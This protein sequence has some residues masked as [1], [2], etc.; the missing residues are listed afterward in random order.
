MK[1]FFN[2]LFSMQLTV[3]LLLMFALSIAIATFIEN[4]YGPSAAKVAVYNATWFEILLAVL[5]VNLTGSMFIHKLWQRKRYV[6]FFMHFSFVIIILG[7]AIT[8][9]FGYEGIMHIREGEV[10]NRMLSDNTYISASWE[11]EGEQKFFR[12]KVLFSGFGWQSR[13]FTLKD[14]DI[15]V[16]F[17]TV[18][19]I[20]DA[21]ATIRPVEDGEPI[22]SLFVLTNTDR[23]NLL[24]QSGEIQNVEGISVSFGNTSV[25]SD[26]LL[27]I[28]NDSLFLSARD[29]INRNVMGAGES[30]IIPPGR[31]TPFMPMNFYTTGNIKLVLR[32]F[33]TRGMVFPSRSDI[34]EHA[35]GQDA[36]I[37]RASNGIQ[38]KDVVLWGRRGISGK[39]VKVSGLGLENLRLS[40]GSVYIELPFS[41][42]LRDFILERYPA[43]NSPSSY[44]S[45]IT[46]IDKEKG[47]QFDYRIFMNNILSHRGYRFYQSSYDSDELGTILSVNHDAPGTIVTYAGYA[48]MIL[49]MI[50][51]FIYPRTRFR[52]LL[53][54][55]SEV[56]KQ[57]LT[58]SALVFFFLLNGIHSTHGQNFVHGHSDQISIVDKQHAAR[59]GELIVLGPD[60][61]IKPLNTLNSELIRKITG[62]SSFK[63][64][65]PDQIIL[66]MLIEP[67]EWQHVP[68]FRVKNKNIRQILGITES[69]AR[70]VDFFETN[71]N[72]KL[73][74]YVEEAYRKNPAQQNQFDKDIIAIDE[75]VNIFYNILM[76]NYLHI[77]PDVN[78][79]AERWYHP[80]A[81]FDGFPAEDSNF[82][83]NI[84]PVYADELRKAVQ[85]S[86]YHQ[87]DELL[88]GIGL[89]QRKYASE[90]L[91]SETKLKME[92]LYNKVEIFER[93]Y[94][95]YGLVGF[96][97]L[98]ILFARLVNPRFQFKILTKIITVLLV[99]F[100]IFHT[101]GLALRWYV[102]G[103]A[104]LSNGYESM[105]Y[106]AWATMLAGLIFVRKSPI[107]L[108]ATA[109]LAS[110]TLFVA[111]LN[112]MNPEITNLVPVLK[113][114]WLTIHVGVITASYGFLGLVMIMGLFNLIL[115]IFQNRR[116]YSS[117]SLTIKEITLTNEIAMTIGLYLLTIG[118]FLGGIWANE[119]WGRY[120]GWDPKETW[121]LVTILVYTVILHL[122]YIPGVSGTFLFNT[123]S[124]I[125]FSSVLMTYFGVNYYLS[126]LHSYAA[127]DPVPIPKF[128][129]YTVAILLVIIIMAWVNY[130]K[131]HSLESSSS[132]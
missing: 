1:S 33:E 95:Y 53:K 25:N 48:L 63:G 80:M 24:L 28:R 42:H 2:Q 61:R 91:P 78:R 4:D 114:V 131:Y 92:L 32:Q 109:V 115:M 106:I 44:A 122:G 37:L 72:Y 117:F 47:I 68:L 112:W 76:G 11:S 74:S 103:R 84:I 29:T 94:R 102:A 8:R 73:A 128:L 67:Q 18:A 54:T 107:A 97:F 71:Q 79:P 69:R 7:G 126:G 57:K 110:L 99:V 119:S 132:T 60:G 120:W 125:G 14:N 89:F 105:I 36:V 96:L 27:E 127:G 41:L 121:S 26:I 118:S 17:K 129:Y 19:Y 12:K 3:V 70:F 35:S 31:T 46:L 10:T 9:F 43:S 52:Y 13:P 5:T 101:A 23:K 83:A 66:G 21:V 38:E 65:N 15:Q 113:S 130:K 100:F 30:E 90:L 39:E 62:K 108:A 51:M 16:R 34:R 98:L 56:H 50:T 87:A 45:E 104:P 59:F 20:P 22:V 81:T 116:N 85:S 6:T 58:L 88:K 123:L 111:H 64:L 124:V 93:L 86:S 55:L 40:Y 82:V 77:F 75:R 49:A